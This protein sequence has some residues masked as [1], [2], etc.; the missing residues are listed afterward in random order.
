FCHP[1]DSH[2]STQTNKITMTTV[3][4]DNYDSFTWNIYQYLCS[5]GANVQVFRNDKITIEELD[6]LNPI[7][8]VI[9]P[10]PGH[11]ADSAGISKAAIEHFAGKI[12]VLGVCLGEQCIFEVYGG[13]VGHAGEIVHGKTS[14]IKHD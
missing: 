13:K 2:P 3:M 14:K 11:P 12:P 5:L 1:Q 10:G 8:L 4:I 6:A 7:N 9:S